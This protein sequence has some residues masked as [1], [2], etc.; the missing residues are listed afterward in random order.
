MQ[1]KKVIDRLNNPPVINSINDRSL[2]DII[3]E[4]LNEFEDANL[5]SEAAT[6][7]IAENIY[8]VVMETMIEPT[9]ADEFNK[10]IID[11]NDLIVRYIK[12][13]LDVGQLKYGKSIPKD[14][15]RNM[16]Q[17]ALEEIFDG[18]VYIANK[19]LDLDGEEE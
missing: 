5:G 6:K 7:H 8:N 15:G 1:D 11:R 16:E 14:D 19:L 3:Q 9:T 4:A 13:R 10:P 18:M 12:E 17:E 2:V